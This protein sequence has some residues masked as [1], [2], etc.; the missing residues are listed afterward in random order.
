[1]GCLASLISGPPQGF[2]EFRAQPREQRAPCR[3][4]PVVDL[5]ERHVDF[6]AQAPVAGL[7][8]QEEDV[9]GCGRERA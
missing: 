7:T 9:L 6:Q 3:Y 2:R 5:E 1:M 8:L 4:L